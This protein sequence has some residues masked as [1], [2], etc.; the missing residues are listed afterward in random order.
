[1]CRAT[2][3]ME[4]AYELTVNAWPALR[5]LPALLDSDKDG[6]PDEWE[7]KNGLNAKDG[8]DSAVYKIDKKYTNVEMYL[9][10]LI[11]Q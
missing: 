10:S 9:N 3:H 11:T 6:M 8:S 2:T 4:T 1:M 7:T 5:S